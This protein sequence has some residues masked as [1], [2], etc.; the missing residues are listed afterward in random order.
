MTRNKWVT[1]GAAIM[2]AACASVTQ[3]DSTPGGFSSGYSDVVTRG[4]GPDR[5]LFHGLAGHR[6][7]WVDAAHHLDDR[8]KLHMVQIKGFAGIPAR[9]DDRLVVSRIAQEVAR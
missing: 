4:A 3:T 9:G 8:Y 5:S 2:L 7:L 6:D 1:F